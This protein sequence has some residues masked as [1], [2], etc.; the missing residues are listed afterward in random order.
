LP[1]GVESESP[2]LLT[3]AQD[4][5]DNHA[6]CRAA[7][8]LLPM[9]FGEDAMHLGDLFIGSKVFCTHPFT[10]ALSTPLAFLE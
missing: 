2:Q 10:P 5:R 1:R 8:L 7:L 9:V 6:R 3:A 4:L